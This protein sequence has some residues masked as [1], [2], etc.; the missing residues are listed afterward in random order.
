MTP[1]SLLC[2][3][4]HILVVLVLFA[5]AGRCS[6]GEPPERLLADAGRSDWRI[7]IA[8]DAPPATRY[9]A[10]E[11]QTFFEKITGAR[12]PIAAD[13]ESPREREILVGR[14]RRLDELRP[15][16][17]F[18]GL[19]C[20]GYEL[21]TQG[22]KLI[23]AGGEP[24]GTLYGVYGL[25]ED[26]WGCRWFTPEVE[27]VPRIAR[28]PLPALNERKTPVFEYRELD[29]WEGRDGNWMARN[30]LNGSSGRGRAADRWGVHSPA[31]WIEA[32]HGGDIRFGSGFFVHTFEKLAPA[33]EY[34][35]SHPEYYALVDGKRVPDQLCCTNEEVIRVCAEA[36]RNGIRQQPD[37]TV[38]SCSQNDNG[39]YCRCEQCQ[40]LAKAQESQMAPVLHLVNRVA[41]SVAEQFPGKIIE[42]LAYTW[43]RKAPNSM[44]P[45]PNVVIRLCDIECCFSHPLASGCSPGNDAF[46]A[47][48]KRWALV[49]NRLW[50][51]DYTTNFNNYLLPHP[52]KRVIDDNL[53]LFA[54]NHVTGAFEQDSGHTAGSE[55]AELGGYLTAKLL[56]NPD[57]GEDRAINEFLDGYYGRAASSIRRYVDL[58]HD[59]V[60]NRPI[61]CNCYTPPSSQHLTIPL[62]QTADRLWAEAESLVEGDPAL[63]DRVRRS[64]M[65][66]D[67][68]IVER[69]RLVLSDGGA[70]RDPQLQPLIALARGRIEPFIETLKGSNVA[71]PRDTHKT[72]KADYIRELLDLQAAIE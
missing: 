33:K 26:T 40:A 37:A 32:R 65:S 52:N 57:Y 55:L 48:L 23:V 58:L 49:S 31:P 14:S 45:R 47:D 62:L 3:L 29:L 1:A 43:T 18:D 54:A 72:T 63:L 15:P 61:H 41:E 22:Q 24:R 16:V 19:G 59:R 67:Y 35:A 69:A 4:P 70:R 53:R 46:V 25:L 30:R 27:H 5:P 17:D 12:L 71:R 44:R 11:L 56:W 60:E 2:D 38:F 9:A 42:T 21:R 36:I 10:E 6:G 20:E 28:L 68:A 50:I 64:R 66:V 34:F 51:W 39:N 13:R 7:V 8:A